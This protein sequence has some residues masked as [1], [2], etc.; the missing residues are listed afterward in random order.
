MG[1][2]TSCRAVIYFRHRCRPLETWE[3]YSTLLQPSSR[4]VSVFAVIEDNWEKSGV[5]TRF[6]LSLSHTHALCPCVQV[7]VSRWLPAATWT[8]R[9]LHET[10][11]LGFPRFAD[12][13]RRTNIPNALR[14]ASFRLQ[15]RKH[16]ALF[17]KMNLPPLRGDG[18]SWEFDYSLFPVYWRWAARNNVYTRVSSSTRRLR[19]KRI[20]CRWFRSGLIASVLWKRFWFPLLRLSYGQVIWE[21]RGRNS[22]KRFRDVET[23]ANG[24][25]KIMDQA[26][27]DNLLSLFF[28]NFFDIINVLR[29]LML[30]EL[31]YFC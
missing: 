8:I 30:G 22:F 13:G 1:A 10:T 19:C 2:V 5:E 31:V 17:V 4:L 28:C 6:S 18:L 12:H 21:R 7:R 15:A 20:G 25:I 11:T 9:D 3:D 26:I 24:F 27:L 16:V 14:S 23:H 29:S